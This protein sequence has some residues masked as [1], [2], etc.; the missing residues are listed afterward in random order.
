VVP[1][2]IW[3]K[4]QEY[5]SLMMWAQ[6]AGKATGIVT[7]DRLTGASPAGTYAHSASRDWE[8]VGVTGCAD[9]AAQLVRDSPG[10][11]V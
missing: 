10:H 6:H 11:G 9:I 1:V 5:E 4:E 8:G 2:E 3:T 7:T